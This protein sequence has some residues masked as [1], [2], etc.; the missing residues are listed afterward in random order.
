MILLS[1]RW[2]NKFHYMNRKSSLREPHY[3]PIKFIL[4]AK[5]D[6][7]TP[8]GKFVAFSQERDGLGRLLKPQNDQ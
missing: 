5:A 6:S 7:P 4:E 2:A 1:N 8:Q 3:S